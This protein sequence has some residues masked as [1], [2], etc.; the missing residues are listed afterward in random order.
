MAIIR[1]REGKGGGQGEEVGEEGEKKPKVRMS[2]EI[3][4]AWG[5]HQ[6]EGLQRSPSGG[7]DKHASPEFNVGGD[8][9]RDK[10]GGGKSMGRAEEYSGNINTNLEP[11]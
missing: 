10:Q 11:N 9:S 7:G 2:A 1:G 6:G 3:G 5:K 4:G 8:I